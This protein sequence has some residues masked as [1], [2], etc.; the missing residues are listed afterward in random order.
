MLKSAAQLYV[1]CMQQLE[2][3]H[4]FDGGFQPWQPPKLGQVGHVA[5]S[6]GL[7]YNALNIALCKIPIG[8]ARVQSWYDRYPYDPA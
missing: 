4:L 2:K 3:H 7:Q 1:R 5:H 6:E 8:C